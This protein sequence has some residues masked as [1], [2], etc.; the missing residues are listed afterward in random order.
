MAWSQ[1]NPFVRFLTLSLDGWVCVLT[2]KPRAGCDSLRSRVRRAE[3]G[4][5]DGPGEDPHR[6]ASGR[7]VAPSR[8]GGVDRGAAGCRTDPVPARSDRTTSSLPDRAAS[9]TLPR[10]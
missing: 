1:R 2:D 4:L 7:C 5:A 8:P 6:T 10:G 9:R 3:K